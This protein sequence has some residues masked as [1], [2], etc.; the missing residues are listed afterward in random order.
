MYAKA[1]NCEWVKHLVE[2]LSQ[3]I[4]GG[5]MTPIE[6]KLKAVHDWATLANIKDVRSFMGFT[7]YYQQFV[8]HFATLAIPLRKIDQEGDFL[9]M[10][11]ISM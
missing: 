1:S 3:Q 6:V 9:A 4:I 8:K 11:S 10:G 2:F 7:N 5:N